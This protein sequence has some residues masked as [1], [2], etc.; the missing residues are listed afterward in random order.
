MG[1]LFS[2][3]AASPKLVENGTFTAEQWDRADSRATNLYYD[4]ARRA[5]CLK[6]GEVKVGDTFSVVDVPLEQILDG[7]KTDL[8][9]WAKRYK[10]TAITKEAAP[11]TKWGK[12]TKRLSMT[13]QVYRGNSLGA[14]DSYMYG[15]I[16][17]NVNKSDYG[18]WCTGGG[19]N[20]YIRTSDIDKLSQPFPWSGEAWNN[21]VVAR[22]AR[23]MFKKGRKN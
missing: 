17:P 13:R 14:E 7:T 4:K 3:P 9:S 12:G 11:A 16:G 19:C 8:K 5:T 18:Y 21:K 2:A 10:V 20:S 22:Q 23:K 15:H 1:I 6:L